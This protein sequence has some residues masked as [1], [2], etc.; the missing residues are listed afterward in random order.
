METIRF[1]SIAL[2]EPGGATRSTLW[3][4]DPQSWPFRFETDRQSELI[5]TSRLLTGGCA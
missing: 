2:P 1:A 4:E 3:S 5:L